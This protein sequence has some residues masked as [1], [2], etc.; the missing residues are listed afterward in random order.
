MPALRRTPLGSRG[1]PP[2][3]VGVLA[4]LVCAPAWAQS[5]DLLG[6]VDRFVRDL[7]SDGVSTR[8]E[9]GA[10]L[11]AAPGIT[12]ADLEREL[13]RDDLS[14]EQRH[15]LTAAAYTR[16]VNE[17]R[18]AMGVQFDALPLESGVRIAHAEPGFDSARVLRVGDRLDAIDGVRIADSAH[19][20]AIIQS[21]S[22][23]DVVDIAIL[24]NGTPM[25]VRL[26]LGSRAML[27]SA[28]SLSPQAWIIRSEPYARLARAATS[29]IDS[30]LPPE[31][32]S[33]RAA[34][35]D[36]EAA[37]L[38]RG[39]EPLGVV[40][41]GEPRGGLTP[42]VLSDSRNSP[43][44]N[45]RLVPGA[46]GNAMDGMRA[47]LQVFRESRDLLAKRIELN[48]RRMENPN[49]PE[50]SRRALESD[51]EQ[52]K[53]AIGGLDQQIAVFEEILRRRP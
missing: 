31:A 10:T 40:V 24:R 6:Q 5:V 15:R 53:N 22:P 7:D 44:L 18:A 48:Q 43:R 35:Q 29:A 42:P 50:P 46:A 14:A 51:I 27:S 25:T 13:L 47:Q 11:A 12:L 41:G 23:G 45:A 37:R 33:F 36:G 21:H 3:A 9:A 20:I 38:P 8:M 52:C 4:A 32:W 2:P 34:E 26:T 17:P 30:G 19:A 1:W 16:F 49:L 28:T 39:Y